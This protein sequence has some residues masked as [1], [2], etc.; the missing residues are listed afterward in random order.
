MDNITK[1]RAY[2]LRMAE[3]RPNTR[4]AIGHKVRL[5]RTLRG[6]DQTALGKRARVSQKHISNIENGV[7]S[8][9]LDIIE[10]VA[11]GLDVPAWALISPDLPL[12][13][14]QSPR[15]AKLVQIYA[16]L[17]DDG[18]DILDKIAEREAHFAKVR[19]K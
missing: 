13:L 9:S 16:S 18:R 5:L 6:W 2:A 11:T 14:L 19:N 10:K 4:T 12:E 3:R 7:V 1:L 8:P 15:L 17:P